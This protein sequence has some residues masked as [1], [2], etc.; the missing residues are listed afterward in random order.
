MRRNPESDQ[1]KVEAA[2]RYV[3]TLSFTSLRLYS[4]NPES[5][6]A[7]ATEPSTLKMRAL[8]HDRTAMIVFGDPIATLIASRMKRA[9]ILRTV[10]YTPVDTCIEFYDWWKKS[11]TI[12]FHTGHGMITIGKEIFL[13]KSNDPLIISVKRVV[14]AKIPVKSRR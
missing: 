10:N 9:S 14:Q 11:G 4:E 1:K 6:Y 3:Q 13:L 12:Y 8:V 7:F 5:K 2:R